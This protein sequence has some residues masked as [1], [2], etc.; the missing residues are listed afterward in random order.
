MKQFTSCHSLLSVCHKSV[1][2]VLGESLSSVSSYKHSEAKM[3]VVV[4]DNQTCLCSVTCD[5]REVLV[6]IK[7]GP[8]SLVTAFLSSQC[9]YCWSSSSCC[10]CHSC[11]APLWLLLYLLWHCRSFW[12]WRVN[13]CRGR[14]GR[15][16]HSLSDPVTLSG[17]QCTVLAVAHFN[18]F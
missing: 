2:D 15:R 17:V 13:N 6:E 8:T 16:H 12:S 4:P 18:M 5:V 10:I 9:V 3:W 11:Y 7:T 1:G 14:L